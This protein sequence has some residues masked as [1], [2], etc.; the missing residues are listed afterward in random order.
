VIAADDYQEMDA[1]ND[2]SAQDTWDES[3]SDYD[4]LEENNLK[5]FL[6]NWSVQ[7]NIPHVALKPL[8]RKLKRY[9]VHANLPSDP[10]SLLST[11]REIQKQ[12]LFLPKNIAM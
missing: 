8:L 11:H 9:P 4:I 2:E 6:S 12:K 3:K 1:V 10:R 7:Y 5:K